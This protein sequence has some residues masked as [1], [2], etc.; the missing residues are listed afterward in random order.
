MTEAD[1]NE[2]IGTEQI[3]D[4]EALHRHAADLKRK[5]D[6]AT[7][8]YDRTAWIRYAAIF[9]P[10]PFAVLLLRLH[11]PAWGYYVAGALFI[12]V[13]G[14]MYALDLAAVAKRDKT[15]Q[16][17]QRAQEAYEEAARTSRRDATF[18]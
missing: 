4:L 14:M 7:R 13:A 12:A 5:A 2:A 15:I 10:V 3:R 17:A 9:I 16:A 11:M 8:T 6:E 18:Q 1:A